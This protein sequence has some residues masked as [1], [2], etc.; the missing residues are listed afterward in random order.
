M[1]DISIL[2]QQAALLLA[3]FAPYLIKGGIEAAKGAAGKVGELATEKGWD[4][5]QSMWSK[6]AKHEGVKKA[7]E[8]IAKLPEDADA[9]AALRLQIKLALSADATLVEALEKFLA[10]AT[11]KSAANAKGSRSVAI[12]GHVKDSVIIAGNNNRVGKKP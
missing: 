12:G 9:Q 4:K 11:G 8:T 3:P 6:L 1:S 7:A 10:E 2:A 5:I